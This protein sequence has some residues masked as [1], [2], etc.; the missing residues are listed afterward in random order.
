LV[1]FGATQAFL[2]LALVQLREGY[3]GH[4]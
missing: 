4:V 1:K 2:A 3:A